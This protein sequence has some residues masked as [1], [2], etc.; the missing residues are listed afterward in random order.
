MTERQRDRANELSIDDYKRKHGAS[1]S[2]QVKMAA[3][4]NKT[5]SSGSGC[6]ILLLLIPAGLF[7]L[8]LTCITL[9]NDPPNVGNIQKGRAALSEVM[10]T[11]EDSQIR[12]LQSVTSRFSTE[13][14]LLSVGCGVAEGRPL[15]LD[16]IANSH[17]LVQ[18]LRVQ[19]TEIYGRS[20]DR[21]MFA[22][23]Q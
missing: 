10:K 18:P 5:S 15:K 19:L 12:F 14:F 23:D 6:A 4:P 17:R 16:P 20:C 9:L 8:L 21:C 7:S 13:E 2:E 22:R 3:R 1:D 11:D